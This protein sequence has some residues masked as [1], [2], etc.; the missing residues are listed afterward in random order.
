MRDPMTD[1]IEFEGHCQCCSKRVRPE[2]AARWLG[3]LFRV[4]YEV[5]VNWPW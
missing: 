4:A 5:A 2:R 1:L 3:I